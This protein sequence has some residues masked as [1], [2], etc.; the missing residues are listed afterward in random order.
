[1]EKAVL[2]RDILLGSP[3]DVK[4][5]WV[6]SSGEFLF[7]LDQ[8]DLL[9]SVQILDHYTCKNLLYNKKHTDYCIE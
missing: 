1:M 6:D 7:C 9:T 4:C 3:H 2:L 8:R 5:E